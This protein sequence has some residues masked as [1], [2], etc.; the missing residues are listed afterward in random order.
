MK[1]AVVQYDMAWENPTINKPKITKLV[2]T[3]KGT[4]IDWLIFPEATLT[5]FSMDPNRTDISDADMEFF[6]DIADIQ[7]CFVTFGAFKNKKNNLFTYSPSGELVS[8]YAKMHLFSYADE[9]VT[10][11][12]G[13][14][15]RPFTVGD[16]NVIPSICYDLRFSYLYWD[17]AAS[18]DVFL[19]SANWPEAR[20]EHWI[21]LLKARAIENQCFVIGVNRVGKD[22]KVS[23]SGD[24]MVIDPFGRIILDCGNRE[25]V[26]KAELEKALVAKTRETYPFLNDRIKKS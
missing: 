13:D 1:V 5:G 2:E 7:E 16:F 25:G 10:Y 3:L 26:F 4:K 18:T 22:P 19:V 14:A 23:Y 15:Q 21:T 17:N 6:K 11:K 24:S 8:D 12:A 20:R 9:H